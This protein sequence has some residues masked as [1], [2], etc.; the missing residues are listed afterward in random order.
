MAHSAPKN[1][2][3]MNMTHD[4]KKL[5]AC[6][7]AGGQ[8]SGVGT[9]QTPPSTPTIAVRE[10]YLHLLSNGTWVMGAEDSQKPAVGLHRS[11]IATQITQTASRCKVQGGIFWGRCF[12]V[13]GF[14]QG[15][16]SARRRSFSPLAAL[17]EAIS[18]RAALVR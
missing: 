2:R 13:L 12:Q 1:D 14:C 16:L 4:D 5:N 8:S 3:D 15:F 18:M 6:A 9:T 10:P 7:M 17:P 11:G